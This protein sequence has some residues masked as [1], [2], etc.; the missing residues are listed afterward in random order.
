M[1]RGG[2]V[3][4]RWDVYNCSVLLILLFDFDGVRQAMVSGGLMVQ[5]E[6]RRLGLPWK[7]ALITGGLVLVAAVVITALLVSDSAGWGRAIPYLVI[8]FVLGTAL[9][10]LLF[11]LTQQ[12]L[13]KLLGDL[14]E[15]DGLKKLDGHTGDAGVLADEVNRLAGKTGGQV[16]V[17][18]KGSKDPA[19][20]AFEMQ[21]S[22]LPKK[23][24]RYDEVRVAGLCLPAPRVSG[25]YY[26]F[27][28][29]N[30]RK[31]GVII[32][33]VSEKGLDGLFTAQMLKSM[34]RVIVKRYEEP[35]PTICELNRHLTPEMRPG[36]FVTGIYLIY[37]TVAHTLEF[38]NSGHN[39][40]LVYR[41]N[42]DNIEVIKTRGRPLGVLG[43]KEFEGKLEDSRIKLEHGD[44]ALLYND[45]LTGMMNSS[46]EQFGQER[47]IEGFRKIARLEP[48][49]LIKKLS[50]LALN[51]AGGEEQLDDMTLVAM[52]CQAKVTHFET[53]SR[54]DTHDLTDLIDQAIE[55]K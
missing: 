11:G 7:Q 12:P 51:F 6:K 38:V 8:V 33:D 30:G 13:K 5:A 26:D 2:V 44:V 45:G 17:A 52:R 15:L 22:L 54:V 29:L 46:E 31:L 10:L 53:P 24:P 28:R 50:S 4:L 19:F 36:S 32:T 3:N 21:R 55:E 16:E 47:L 48:E 23:T 27:I 40:I 34:L 14:R 43:T 39:P 1:S 49:S 41:Y 35:L 37:D 20:V 42:E 25:D 9:A 18:G